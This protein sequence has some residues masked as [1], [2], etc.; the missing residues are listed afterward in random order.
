MRTDLNN[1]KQRSFLQKFSFVGLIF[2]GIGIPFLII[3]IVIQFIPINPETMTV[4]RNGVRQIATEETV[5]VFRLIFLGVFGGLG[6]IFSVIGGILAFHPIRKRRRLEHLKREGAL[7]VADAIGLEATHIR[8]NHRRLSYLR[9]S[10]ETPIGETYIFK[11]DLLRAD[12]IP[13]LDD[14]KVNVYYE[15]DN[16]KEYFVDVDGSI[17]LGSRFFEL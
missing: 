10:Y 8:V 7:L 3:G 1:V 14:G 15:R 6:L 17:G 16:M 9:C 13:H 11:S 2:L 4:Y 5:R 12:P